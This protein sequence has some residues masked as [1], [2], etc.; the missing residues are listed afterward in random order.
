M[1]G[2]SDKVAILS[3]LQ[4]LINDMMDRELSHPDEMT[5]DVSEDAVEDLGGVNTMKPIKKTVVIAKGK[6]DI[7]DDMSWVKD[8]F[9]K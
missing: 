9:K 8:L 2:G 5:D 3:V 4:E 1:H 7:P 6:G